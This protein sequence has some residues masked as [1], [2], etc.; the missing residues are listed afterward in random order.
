[1]RSRFKSWRARA[2]PCLRPRTS[3][4][5]VHCPRPPYEYAVWQ[6]CRVNIDYHIAIQGSYYSVPYTL[7]S[8]QVDTR[9]TQRTV[10]IF[11]KGRRVA[12]HQRVFHKGQYQTNALHRPKSHQRH[13][14]WTPSRLIEWGKSIGPNTGILV[15]RIMQKYPHPEQGY[16]SCLGLIS[17]GRRYPKERVEVASARALL[18]NSP[19]YKS[20]QS[21]LKSGLDKT[22]TPTNDEPASHLHGNI[23]GAS[24]YQ[25]KLLN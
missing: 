8:Q 24:Y 20:V 19:S 13:L 18:I 7:I 12:S 9:L 25:S 4:P 14:E 10:E 15:E 17:L 1:M 3:P 22:T 11:F 21:I 6:L 5:S 2:S 23:R 16:R